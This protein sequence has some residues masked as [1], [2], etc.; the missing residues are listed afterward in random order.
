M[1]ST[2]KRDDYTPTKAMRFERSVH[3]RELVKYSEQVQRYFNIF[4]RDRV[5]VIIYD[6]FACDTAS[7]FESTLRFLK[8]D[9]DIEVDLSAVNTN[10]VIR[11][12]FL[13]NLT[14]NPK[15]WKGVVKFVEHS[16][17]GRWQDNAMSYN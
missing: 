6:D 12:R 16:V 1:E 9:P 15:L 7:V 8:V 4:G 2:R 11:N 17:P 13:W 3:Y 14:R 10:T 5:K